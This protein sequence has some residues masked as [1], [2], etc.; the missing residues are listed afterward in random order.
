M[1][2]KI[3]RF[4]AAVAFVLLAVGLIQAG[5][6]LL[7]LG[8]GLTGTLALLHRWRDSVLGFGSTESGGWMIIILAGLVFGSLVYRQTK[9]GRY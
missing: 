3:L 1:S 8:T 9:D 5:Y 7:I 4:I 2:G 6:N